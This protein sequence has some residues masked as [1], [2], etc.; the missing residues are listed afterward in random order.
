MPSLIAAGIDAKHSN[1]DVIGPYYRWIDGYGD[2]IGLFGGIEMD[3][4]CRMEP[5]DIYEF[6]IEEGARFRATANGFALGSRNSIPDYVPVDG[7]LAMVRAVQ[8]IRRRETF[9]SQ[10]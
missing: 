5:D 1:E 8:E 7:Y 3:R 10:S 2:R 4:L 6:V 9:R